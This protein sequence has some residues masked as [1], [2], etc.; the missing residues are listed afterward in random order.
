MTTRTQAHTR[1]AS[2]QQSHAAHLFTFDHIASL[3]AQPTQLRWVSL[4]VE[5]CGT[6]F[7]VKGG[8]M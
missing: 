6:A 8:V 2:S 4:C 5:P 3:D 7:A 1:P